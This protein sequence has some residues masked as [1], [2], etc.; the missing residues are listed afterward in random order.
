M[1]ERAK[2]FIVSEVAH[3]KDIN[4]REAEDLVERSLTSSLEKRTRAAS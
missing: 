3:V 4:E 1:Y 2:Y